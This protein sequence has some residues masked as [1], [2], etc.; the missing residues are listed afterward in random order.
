MNLE[1]HKKTGLYYRP[2]T[3]DLTL[4]KEMEH[5]EYQILW[6]MCKDEVILDLGGYIGDSSLYALNNGAKQVISLEPSPNNLE[7][8][9]LQKHI[10]NPKLILLEEAVSNINGTAKFYITKENKAT[11]SHSLKNV[12]GREE[13]TVKTR[14]WEELLNEYNPTIIKMDCEGGE[15]NIDFNL[16]NNKVKAIMCELHPKFCKRKFERTEEIINV[17]KEKFNIVYYKETKFFNKI[18]TILIT[19]IQK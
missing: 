16:I 12:R 10:N 5:K 8:Y 7:V 17:L 1:I 2:G 6:D 13:Y 9:K 19:G 3:Q 4:I 14:K 18:D 15:D 11:G